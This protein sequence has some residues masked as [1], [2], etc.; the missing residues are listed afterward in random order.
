M[1]S[2]EA[3]N[4]SPAAYRQNLFPLP[5]APTLKRVMDRTW[6]YT[7]QKWKGR[8]VCGLHE[9]VVDGPWPEAREVGYRYPLLAA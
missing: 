7:D 3:G 2:F 6:V 8:G 9:A 5:Q 1:R 4:A